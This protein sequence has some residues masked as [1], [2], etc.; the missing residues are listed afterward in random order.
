MFPTFDQ[1]LSRKKDDVGHYVV[2]TLNLKDKC[3]QLI[4]SLYGV[5]DHGGWAVFLKMVKYIRKLWCDGS[6]KFDIPLSPPS[7]DD[8]PTNY[9]DTVMQDNGWDSM[10]I[11]FFTFFIH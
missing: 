6:E 9:M 1:H 10:V 11:M 3:F 2:V 4:D 8:F 7:I 5:N